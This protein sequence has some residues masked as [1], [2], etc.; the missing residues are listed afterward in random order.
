MCKD[1]Q[2]KNQKQNKVQGIYRKTKRQN[3]E[4]KND[5]KIG[6]V[7][8]SIC[9]FLWLLVLVLNAIFDL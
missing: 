4:D 7:I 3:R 6:A 9:V 5:N 2:N 1:G 8:V